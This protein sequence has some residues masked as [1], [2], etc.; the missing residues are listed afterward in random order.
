MLE[1]VNTDGQLVVTELSKHKDHQ[2]QFTNHARIS[3]LHYDSHFQLALAGGSFCFYNGIVSQHT[4]TLNFFQLTHDSSQKRAWVPFQLIQVSHVDHLIGMS[5]H[6]IGGTDP[7]NEQLFVALVSLEGS[8]YFFLI[9]RTKHLDPS[10][11][12]FQNYL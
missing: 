11:D 9:Q 12:L 10:I 4:R 8:F 3:I 5:V 1:V 2:N 6:H 7:Y